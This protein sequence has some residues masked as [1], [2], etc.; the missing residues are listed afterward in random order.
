MNS[1]PSWLKTE[2]DIKRFF[3]LLNFEVK[4]ISIEGAQIDLIAEK[5]DDIGIDKNIYIIEITTEYV[6]KDKGSKDCQKL[7]LG[8]KKYHNAK[9]LL[10]STKGFTDDQTAILKELDIHPLLYS[11]LEASK[12]PL[13]KYAL[14][15]LSNIDEESQSRKDVGYISRFYVDPE[16]SI[17]EKTIFS[18]EWLDTFLNSSKPILWALLADLGSGKTTALEHLLEIGCKKFLDDSSNSP[19]P[20]YI[21]LGKYKQ[22][23]GD[24]EQ[25][26]M[27]EL[28]NNGITDYPSTF[29]KHLIKKRRILLLLDG[30][31][32]V[33]PI[34]NSDDI[35][36][37]VTNLLEN[38]GRDAVSIISSR[39]QFFET[40]QAELAMFGP[41]TAEKLGSIQIGLEKIFR[42][43]PTSAIVNIKPFDRKMIDTYLFKRC[44]MDKAEIDDLFV[45]YYGF[46]K[47]A[48]TPVLLSMIATTIEEK[49]T[50]FSDKITFP[51]IALY[52]AYTN[53]WIERDVQRT[54][55]KKS[56]RLNFSEKL[57]EHMITNSKDS[58][59]WR[60]LKELLMQDDDWSE[61]RL[62]DEEI[63]LDIRKSGFLIRDYDNKYKFIHRSIMEFLAARKEIKNLLN[64]DKISYFRTDG[65]KMFL[66]QL[67][68]LHWLENNQTPFQ[69]HSWDEGRGKDAINSQ[70]LLLSGASQHFDKN[71]NFLVPKKIT[72]DTATTWNRVNFIK[73]NLK[74]IDAFIKFKNCSVDN[75]RIVLD[76]S[77]ALYFDNS[78]I[79]HSN[80]FIGESVNLNETSFDLAPHQLNLFNKKYFWDMAYL[81]D[82][83]NTINYK[84]STFTLSYK[85]LEKLALSLHYLRDNIEIDNYAKSTRSQELLEIIPILKKHKIVEIFKIANKE[86]YKITKD[87][88]SLKT[89]PDTNIEKI[90]KIMKDM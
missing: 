43:H 63:D 13:R 45:K 75:S 89:N 77:S 10:I 70:I 52:A 25:M 73:S 65:Y 85:K 20:L 72:I 3:E 27:N 17:E 1:L 40:N 62:K 59:D 82:Q 24:L 90:E 4:E 56:I 74:V 88:L 15:M 30:L 18:Q 33:H 68:G 38:I 21:P 7:L 26:I 16:F 80:I 51:L 8:A 41:Y 57:A 9:M 35:L 83:G 53:R 49:L 64:G 6:G 44:N 67:V 86:R 31:D 34:Q 78:V 76:G 46:D 14:N 84:K 28:K 47:L 61:S 58:E 37:T 42:N 71:V 81:H 66:E 22:H 54:K 2:Q 23:S 36:D 48:T 50:N 32:E 5:Y 39:K 60:Y 11:D 79:E 19:V 69:V 55:L 12:L 87:G 29:T